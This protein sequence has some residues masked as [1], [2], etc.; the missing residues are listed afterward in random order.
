MANLVPVD[1]TVHVGNDGW[2]F[3][4]KGTNNVIDLYR[5][6]SIFTEEMLQQWRMLLEG[7]NQRLAD[8]GAR[9]VHLPAPEKLTILSDHYDGQIENINGSPIKSLFGS[10]AQAPEYAVNVVPYFSE[11]LEKVQLYWKTDTH[12]SFW[13]AYC[14]YQLLCN[15][16]GFEPNPDLVNYD[17]GQVK[18]VLDLGSKV[19]PKVKEEVRYYRLNR[20]S[21][22]VYANDL[23]QF[24]EKNSLENEGSLHVGSHVVFQ[25]DS[26]SAIDKKVI[27]FGD[28]FSEYRPLLLSG[29]LAETFREVHFLWSGALDFDYIEKVKPDIV[30][31]ELAERFMTKVPV[32]T[33]NIET[34]SAAKLS[35]YLESKMAVAG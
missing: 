5:R 28:S 13:G 20:L 12:W 6:K 11:R 18:L 30:V 31:S 14:A 26:E 1:D 2:L 17:Y 23:V 33:L 22:R 10:Y 24:K 19:E 25:N 7:R 16:L 3:L 32:D 8:L 29:M 34:F 4:V 15:K 9:Y 35:T 21:K 27:L